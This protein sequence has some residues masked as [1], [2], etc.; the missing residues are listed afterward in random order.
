MWLFNVSSGI[1]RCAHGSVLISGVRHT[2]V[3]TEWQR[4]LKHVIKTNA[5]CEEMCVLRC[6]RLS[7]RHSA[8]RRIWRC[9][10]S[11][12]GIMSINE[13]SRGA[14]NEPLSVCACEFKTGAR[15]INQTSFATCRTHTRARC[16]ESQR[17][18]R[19]PLWRFYMHWDVLL[20]GGIFFLSHRAQG[21]ACNCG[22][23]DEMRV[24]HGQRCT[25]LYLQSNDMMA[26]INS[27][28]LKTINAG[29][30]R[31]KVHI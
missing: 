26:N 10:R 27:S 15:E 2:T 23:F 5:F 17:A 25:W 22:V 8:S 1:F 9:T 16:F 6:E 4:W 29:I 20:S 13:G 12:N 18:K 3:P 31:I 7:L 14:F 11:L 30:L 19:P 21:A 28:S 24:A